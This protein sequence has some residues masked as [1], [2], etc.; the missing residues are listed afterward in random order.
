[1][2]QYL[3]NDAPHCQDPDMEILILKILAASKK[4]HGY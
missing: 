1:M 3:N 2:L 4:A